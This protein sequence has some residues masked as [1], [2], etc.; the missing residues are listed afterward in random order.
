MFRA[1][2]ICPDASMTARAAFCLLLLFLLPAAVQAQSRTLRSGVVRAANL[3]PGRQDA[4]TIDARA[5]DLL[6]ARLT[7]GAFDTVVELWSP[8]GVLLDSN[9]DGGVSTNSELEGV[10]LSNGG[11]YRVV[12]RSYSNGSGGAYALLVTLVA[13]RPPAPAFVSAGTLASG[14]TRSRDLAVGAVHGWT[15]QGAA[16]Q[17]ATL[18]LVGSTGLDPYLE[19]YGPDGELLASDDDGGGMLGSRIQVRLPAS[20]TYGVRV[21]DY[22]T[23]SAGRYDLALTLRQETMTDNVFG[24]PQTGQIGPREVRTY[25]FQ[26]DA[27]NVATIT[28]TSTDFDREVALYDPYGAEVARNDDFDGLNSRIDGLQLTSSGTYE[29]TVQGH[30]PSG[31]GAYVLR[32]SRD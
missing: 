30:Q 18:T 16:G 12:V 27:G 1:D 10:R 24:R 11:R 22:G 17:R 3:A 9:D 32:V 15:F 13:G 25:T 26:A 6:S 29:V 19:L 21:R 23:D 5:G 28:L 14:Q 7:S 8:S 20:G 4:W 31:A 2:F